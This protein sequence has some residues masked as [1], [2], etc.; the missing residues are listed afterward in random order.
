VTQ[1]KGGFVI[2]VILVL[3]ILGGFTS[4]NQFA[5]VL[6]TLA[7]GIL[8]WIM[9]ELDWPRPPLVLGLV[10]GRLAENYLFLSMSRYEM[11]WLTRPTVVF[12]LAVIALAILYPV[13]SKRL[14]GI[15]QKIGVT[16]DG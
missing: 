4:S 7:F 5:D 1:L 2:P 15:W 3:I 6:V 9:V 10:L 14:P 12:G 16:D 8:G 11:G 13:F